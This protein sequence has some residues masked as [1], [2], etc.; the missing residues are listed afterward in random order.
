MRLVQTTLMTALAVLALLGAPLAQVMVWCQGSDGHQAVEMAGHQHHEHGQCDQSVSRLQHHD[1]DA[2]AHAHGPCDDQRLASEGQ[3]TPQRQ[4]TL[5]YSFGAIASGTL[6]LSSPALT[7]D[8]RAPKST[9][10]S[11]D[12]AIHPGALPPTLTAVIL[13]I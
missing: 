11:M 4:L 3:P 9:R 5:T 13:L 7:G 10:I 2:T 1:H 12:Q 6:S 8:V